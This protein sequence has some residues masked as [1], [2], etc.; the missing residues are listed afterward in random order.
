MKNPRA[1]TNLEITLEY[2][3]TC[4]NFQKCARTIL[5]FAFKKNF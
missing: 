4:Q 2:S 3:S 1:K 5:F